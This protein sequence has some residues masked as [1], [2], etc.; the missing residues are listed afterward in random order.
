MAEQGF[1]FE[2]VP[3]R[4]ADFITYFDMFFQTGV[5]KGYLNE[6]ATT[7]PGTNMSSQVASGGAILQGRA[8]RN[9]AIKTLTHDTADATYDRIDLIVL[10]SDASLG[11]KNITA[12]IKKGIASAS[13]VAPTLQQDS[14]IFEILIASVTVTHGKS[15]IDN[16]QIADL[17]TF[18]SVIDRS[19]I[20]YL[21]AATTTD[22][23]VQNNVDTPIFLIAVENDGGWV[24]TG[25]KCKVP[26]TGRYHI[27]LFAEIDFQNAG[28]ELF[29][30]LARYDAAGNVIDRYYTDVRSAYDNTRWTRCNGDITIPLNA[31]ESISLVVN[32]NTSAWKNIKTTRLTAIQVDFA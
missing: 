16:S 31:G 18:W 3:Y 5:I 14:T 4:G 30:H 13:P 26:V 9:D 22:Y 32:P 2:G 15:Y 8:Y 6:L 1:P 29:L 12:V 20:P 28:A 19:A 24:I 25:S 7:A 21:H 17:R 11:V 10:R 27:S 23:A